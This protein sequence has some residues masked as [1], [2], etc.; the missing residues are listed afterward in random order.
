M[1]AS[2]TAEVAATAAA[3]SRCDKAIGTKSLQPEVK[4]CQI[5]RRTTQLS[6]AVADLKAR[7]ASLRGEREMNRT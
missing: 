6:L 2:P 7:A 1:G 5:L 4:H 3:T